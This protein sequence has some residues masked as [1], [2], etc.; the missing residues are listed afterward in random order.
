MWTC[1]DSKRKGTLYSCMDDW[2][3]KKIVKLHGYRLVI[4][5]NFNSSSKNADSYLSC[6]VTTGMKSVV[7]KRITITFRFVVFH[8]PSCCCCCCCYF[9]GFCLL[10]VLPSMISM[11]NTYQTNYLGYLDGLLYFDGNFHFLSNSCNDLAYIFFY[12]ML[13]H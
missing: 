7:A 5:V 9:C 4:L 3:L 6:F 13:V 2:C 10:F 8:F 1:Q 11:N 12:W